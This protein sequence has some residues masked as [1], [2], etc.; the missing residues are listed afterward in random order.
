MLRDRH[1]T[2]ALLLLAGK[3]LLIG[4]LLWVRPPAA[5]AYRLPDTGQ[6]MCYDGAGKLISCPAPGQRFFGQDGNYA[7]PQPAYRDNGNGTVTDLNTGLMWQRG[8]EHN[9]SGRAWQAAVDYCG[10]LGLANHND[11][12]LPNRLELISIVNYGRYSPAVIADAFPNCRPFN[13]WSS[14]TYEDSPNDAWC[15][16]FH[17]GDFGLNSKSG[18]HYV[19]C[20]RVVP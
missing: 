10:A 2:T 19:R 17:D 13:Y 15:V 14:S 9:S 18:T 20:V 7:G 11:W 6:T 3:G 12:R 16:A 1:I 4:V 8:D 5:N